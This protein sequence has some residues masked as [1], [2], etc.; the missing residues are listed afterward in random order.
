M[1][2]TDVRLSEQFH[3]LQHGSPEV[4][5][6]LVLSANT[7]LAALNATVKSFARVK[8]TGTIITKID[9]SASLGGIITASI[10][11]QLPI[12]CCGTGQRVPEDLQPAKN[13]RL[14]SKAVSL[15]QNYT[16]QVDKE[17]LAFRYN[18][19]ISTNKG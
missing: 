9:E 1:S 13:H 7:Q 15:M 4:E 8:L 16:E 17:T 18:H 3:K 11:H 19:L 2:Q 5:P 12:S 14:V 6:Y 10:R